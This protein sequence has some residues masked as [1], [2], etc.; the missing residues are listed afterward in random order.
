MNTVDQY[1]SG[2]DTSTIVPHEPSSS[3]A[4]ESMPEHHESESLVARSPQLTAAHAN[5]GA[6]A[7]I[8]TE[9]VVFPTN[10][11]PATQ[12]SPVVVNYHDQPGVAVPLSSAERYNIDVAPERQARWNTHCRQH[13]WKVGRKAGDPAQ[14]H[15]SRGTEVL[16]EEAVKKWVKPMLTALELA[17]LPCKLENDSCGEQS[18][19]YAIKR[20]LAF[21]RERSDALGIDVV[22]SARL[23]RQPLQGPLRLRHYSPPLRTFRTSKDP[24]S[25]IILNNEVLPATITTVS[26]DEAT[27]MYSMP[28]TQLQALHAW[29]PD[30][31]LITVAILA[32]EYHGGFHNHNNKIVQRRLRTIEKILHSG[33]D[34]E[35]VHYLGIASRQFC[36]RVFGA[37]LDGRVQPDKNWVNNSHRHLYVKQYLPVGC[38]VVRDNANNLVIERWFH[39]S[40]RYPLDAVRDLSPFTL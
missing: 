27:W 6:G 13:K 7:A 19:N 11:S 38:V 24:T 29:Y 40:P 25:G 35:G 3:V 10:A 39:G 22:G 34:E 4:N 20:L 28:R 8:V 2:M 33:I 21:I 5:L 30:L 36:E 16:P 17:T 18:R 23:Q 31:D 12:P 9:H 1:E 14:H 37:F 15:F 32:L 26:L